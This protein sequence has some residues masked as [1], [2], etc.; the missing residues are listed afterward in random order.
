LGHFAHVHGYGSVEIIEPLAIDGPSLRI[1][2]RATRAMPW[3]RKPIGFEFRPRVDGLGVSRVHVSVPAMDLRADLQVL[4]TPTDGEHVQL[5]LALDLHPIER[6]RS[7]HPLA[8][9]VPRTLL[10]WLVARSTLAAFAG[11]AANDFPIWENKAYIERPKLAVGD[12]PIGRYRTW[13]RQFYPESPETQ[14]ERPRIV[15]DLTDEVDRQ[16][17]R[18][19][20][21]RPVATSPSDITSP[22]LDQ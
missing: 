5:R 4:P 12:G 17:G 15:I 21:D 13:A 9:L 1:G 20:D 10:E 11:D 7:L 2:Y 14:T 8:G 16:A 22:R 18:G 19:L 6:K 3:S